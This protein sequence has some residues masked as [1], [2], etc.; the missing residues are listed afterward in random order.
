MDFSKHLFNLMLKAMSDDGSEKNVHLVTQGIGYPALGSPAQPILDL[1]SVDLTTAAGGGTLTVMITETGYAATPAAQFF[2]S[3]LTGIYLNSH[4][5]L[6][7]YLDT[8][9]AAFGT[10]TL[11]S[12]GL[13]DNQSDLAS[14]PAIP[15][16][17]SLTGILTIIA[18][19]NS[20]TS[21]DAAI[22][23]APEPASLALL[24]A[25]LGALCMIGRGNLPVVASHARGHAIRGLE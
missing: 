19:A 5:T 10:A 2:L 18:G 9:N 13:L 22:I 12:S 21:I 17:Y 14:V 3:S 6:D 7:T 23:D 25:A 16:P 24:A 4:A 8:T 1:T 11:L 15:G 20:L